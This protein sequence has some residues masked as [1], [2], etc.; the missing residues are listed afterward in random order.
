MK[1]N[2]P[3]L[4]QHLKKGLPPIVVVSGEDPIQKNDALKL[5]RQSAKQAG[6]TERVRLSPDA[7]L[8]EESIYTYL[9]SPSLT[10]EKVLLEL[11]FRAK[12]PLKA[13]S[14]IL[15]QY[16]ENPSSEVA[17]ILD[18][19]KLDDAAKR[20]AWFKKAENKGLAVTIWPI[21]RDQL[22][23]WIKARCQRYK[24]TI[25][26]DAAALLADYVEGN[27]S[28]AAQTI[29][30]LFLLQPTQ[31]I[32]IPMVQSILADESRFTVFDLTDAIIGKQKDR[33]IHILQTLQED[34]FE[35]TIVLWA[36]TRELRIMAAILGGRESGLGW[37]EIFKK[38]RIFPRR[39][40]G[41]RQFLNN[42]SLK[43]CH[44]S[45]VHAADVD[46]I[47]KGASLGNPWH[48]LQILCLRLL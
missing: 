17:L 2:L 38:N 15:M 34:S 47:L 7:G 11:D 32:D 9:Y 28:A 31:T 22:P 20:S 39:Q 40:A 26:S 41:V 13:I 29:E 12:N 14:N 25:S 42:F 18:T 46:K 30:K 45:L 35:P 6:F 24:L 48:A 21:S 37:D 4:N 8:D 5:L 43:K 23:Q 36:I 27:L 44:Q 19:N 1:I 33:I 3:Q 16:F 10:A